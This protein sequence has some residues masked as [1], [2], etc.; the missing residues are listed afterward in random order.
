M[1]HVRARHHLEHLAGDV[2]GTSNSRRRHAEL[3][4]IGLRKGDEVEHGLYRQRI[5]DVENLI[6]AAEG[7]DR[8]NFTGE[9]DGAIERGVNHVVRRNDQKRVAV[10]RRARHHLGR[11]VGGSTRPVLDDECLT[12]PLLQ[13]FSHQAR[14]DVDGLS[15]GKADDDAHR[16]AWI[17]LRIRKRRDG[18]Q[19]GSKSCQM[20]KSAAWNYH[21]LLCRVWETSVVGRKR[22]PIP[23]WGTRPISIR[24]RAIGANRPTSWDRR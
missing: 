10:R 15:R 2:S 24:N 8:S 6:A 20:W 16:P 13:R 22:R 21:A 7:G 23:Y 17:A 11:D 3:P 5:V 9:I 19:R 12:E 18:Q 4:R 14:R 1:Q